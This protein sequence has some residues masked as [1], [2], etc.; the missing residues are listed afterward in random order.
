MFSDKHQCVSIKCDGKLH[1]ISHEELIK[2]NHFARLYSSEMMQ[3]LHI[4][5]H[6][7]QLGRAE[8]QA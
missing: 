6:T 7:A 1:Q 4:K 3:P 5:E 2:D 8:Q